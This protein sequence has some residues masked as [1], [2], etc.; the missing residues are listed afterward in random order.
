MHTVEF[1]YF[2]YKWG[3]DESLIDPVMFHV[4]CK[5]ANNESLI[6]PV[7]FNVKVGQGRA[8]ACLLVEDRLA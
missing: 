8:Q 3:N 2:C 5:W 6:D 7:L 4:L 1:K